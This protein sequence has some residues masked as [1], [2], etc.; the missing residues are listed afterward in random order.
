M[1][2]RIVNVYL[3]FKHSHQK[4]KPFRIEID[5]DLEATIV[6]VK[7]HIYMAHFYPIWI[8]HSGVILSIMAPYYH[9]PP[10][11]KKSKTDGVGID[12]GK[13]RLKLGLKAGDNTDQNGGWYPI[14]GA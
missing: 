9:P 13:N 10:P 14:L 6:E 12:W 8:K 7:I 4:P 3:I 5:I 1:F 11:Q 2:L